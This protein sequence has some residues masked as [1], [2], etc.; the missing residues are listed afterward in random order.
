MLMNYYMSF[1]HVASFEITF[2]MILNPLFV[3]FWMAGKSNNKFAE[4]N[5]DQRLVFPC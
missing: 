1:M 5:M 2:V 3:P 4:V